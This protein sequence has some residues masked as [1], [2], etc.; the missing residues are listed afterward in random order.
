MTHSTQLPTPLHAPPDTS[1]ETLASPI[2]TA[3]ASSKSVDRQAERRT[4]LRA[5]HCRSPHRLALHS[6]VHRASVSLPLRSTKRPLQAN[7]QKS[8]DSLRLPRFRSAALIHSRARARFLQ[9]GHEISC[10]TCRARFPALAT[11]TMPGHATGHTIPH[12]ACTN[13]HACHAKARVRSS[14]AT[15]PHTCHARCAP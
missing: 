14:M 10:F 6:P 13:P 11:Q 4:V 5:L 7:I 9:Q 12:A 15:M 2:P 1:N 3:H 8:M